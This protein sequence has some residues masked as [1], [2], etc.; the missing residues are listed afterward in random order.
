MKFWKIKKKFRLQRA[1]E[2]CAYTNVKIE[3]KN[4]FNFRRF[5]NR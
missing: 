4:V 1:V 2:T 3:M 5:K